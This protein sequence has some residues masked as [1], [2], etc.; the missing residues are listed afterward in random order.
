MMKYSVWLL[1]FVCA[2]RTIRLLYTSLVIPLK[3]KLLCMMWGISCGKGVS[4]R[5]ETIIR[6]YEKK[7]ICIGDGTVFES[8][9]NYNLVGLMNPT[10]LCAPPGG[11]IIIGHHSGF[12]SVVMNARS[13][14]IIG[15]YVNVG[16]NVRILDNDFHPLAWEDRRPPEVGAKVRK[17]DIIIE[18][19]VFIGTNAII[20]KGSHI[21]ARAIVAAGSVVFGLDVPPDSIVKGNPAKVVKLKS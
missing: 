1:P 19:D 7:S 18:D 20:L 9:A 13:T 12:S 5:G 21:G 8:R 11:R 3:T 16:G 17:K 6:A 15:N 4:F 10:I 14:I 2:K